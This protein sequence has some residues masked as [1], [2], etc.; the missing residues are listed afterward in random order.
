MMVRR[1]D[2]KGE[3]CFGHGASDF[4]S[5]TNAVVVLCWLAMRT[6][7][8]K[9]FMDASIGVAWWQQNGGEQILGQ[10]PANLA[11]ARSEIVRVLSAV[12]GVASIESVVIDL[13]TSLRRASVEVKILTIYGDTRTITIKDIR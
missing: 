13:D 12:E 8:G 9:W 11:F 7:L 1:L 5:G 4:I 2:E 10:M 6:T 3:P